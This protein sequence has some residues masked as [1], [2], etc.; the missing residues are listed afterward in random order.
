[1]RQSGR[2]SALPVYIAAGVYVL[3]ALTMPLY[4]LWHFLIAALLTA[5]VWMLADRL[6][7]PKP[8]S[9]PEPDAAPGPV[10]APE[11]PSPAQ[12]VLNEAA[13]ARGEME[14]LAA[15]IGDSA[16]GAKIAALADLSDAIARDGAQDSADLPQ[17]EKFQRYFLPSAI[18]LLEAYD[19]LADGG[20]GETVAASR[21]RIAQTLDK[22][23]TAFR[24]QLD[25]LYKNDAL[26]L[27]ADIRVMEALLAREGLGEDELG[28]ILRRQKGQQS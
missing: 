11:P 27:D 26:D 1:M 2:R 9:I 10:A 15:S 4:K 28:D 25:A 13:R 21:E 3:Y 20:E 19:R 14:R 18:K 16:I 17:I 22:V 8:G 5:G 7:N 23:S 6:L 12:A 24:K